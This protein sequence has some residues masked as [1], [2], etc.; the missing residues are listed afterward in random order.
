[1]IPGQPERLKSFLNL[2][3]GYL[4]GTQY[5]IN[6]DS[7]PESIREDFRKMAEEDNINFVRLALWT[8]PPGTP[9]DFTKYDVCFKAAEQYKIKITPAFPQIPGWVNGKS[10]DPAVRQTYK[11]H[12]QKIVAHF[13]NEP[14][15][16]MWTMD[17]E[18]S[19]GWKVEPTTSTLALYRNW[20]KTRYTSEDEFRRLTGMPSF[21]TAYATNDPGKGAWNNYQAYN[22]W[23]T[24]T[25]YA[26]AEQNLWITNMVRESDPVHPVSSTPPDILHNQ[27]V[28]NGRSM[29]WLA[30]TVDVP[31]MQMETMWHLEMADMPADVLPAQAANVRKCY[32]SARERGVTYT[33]EFLAGQELGESFRIYTPTAEEMVGTCLAHLGEGSKGYLF[34]LWNPL[35]EGPNAGAWSLRELDGSPSDRSEAMAKVGAM[36]RKNNDL[37]YGMWPA[38]THVA[39]LDSIDAA[40]Y[41]HRRS[42][43]FLMS[44]WYAKNQ[45]GFF[46]ALREEGM[47]CDYIDEIGLVDGTLKKYSVVYLPFSMCI[48]DSVAK[49]IKEFVAQGG[50][51][52]ADSMT[53]FTPPEHAPFKEQP[54]AGLQEVFGIKASAAEVVGTGW[55]DVDRTDKSEFFDRYTTSRLPE[56]YL[57][58]FGAEDQTPT[59]LVAAKYLQ[60]VR[61][62][63]AR[64]LYRDKKGRPVVTVNQFGK[65]QA[66]WTGTLLGLTCRPANTPPE[67]Y[68][69][70]A[71]LI[72][73]YMPKAP[74]KLDTSKGQIIIRRLSSSEGDLFVLVNEHRSEKASFKLT[75]DRASQPRELLSPDQPTWKSAGKGKV[76]GTLAPLGAAVIYFPPS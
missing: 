37:L 28:E 11:E 19:R 67:R 2:K 10:D 16:L 44:E 42:Q 29:W 71:D 3:P 47:G 66:I 14:A 63:T 59:A 68:Q 75:F 69:A 38:D 35:R 30:D 22:D 56:Q 20:L 39:M 26:V 55:M 7:T 41:L 13:R 62:T 64:V 60:P 48:R 49:A 52:I 24:F 70:V 40:I 53:A 8:M 57:P 32:N 76:K 50:T 74:W 65:G 17:I 51:I 15:L 46:K 61:P 54:G 18:P 58:Y 45:Y 6:P 27:V 73:P 12:I 43:Y 9:L 23:L 5:W 1:M 4:H 21:A 25:C 31:S 72:R 34:W 33:G 36:I